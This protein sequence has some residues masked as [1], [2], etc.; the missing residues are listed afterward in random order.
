MGEQQA[1]AG[2]G[3][4]TRA[5]HAGQAPDPV[6]RRGRHADLAVDDVRP[7]RRRRPPGLRVLALGQPD[8]ARAGGVR[9]LARAG[10]PRPGVRQRARRRGQ[11]PAPRA[12]RA[13]GSLLGNDAYG[14]TFRLIAKVWGPHGMTVDGGRPHRPR[15]PRRQLAGGHGDG[16]AGDADQPAA[17]VHRHRGRRRRRPRQRRPRRRRQHVRHAVPAA[18]DHARRR[19]RRALGDEV[20]RRAQR[21]RR[22]V[23]RRRRRRPRRAAAVHAERRRRGARRRSTATSCCAA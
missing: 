15:R 14:G 16:V 17:D 18:A 1:P 11:R 10:P 9:R 8:A 13:G 12:V 21:R 3:F 5:V 20:P 7:G 4:E 23:R 22:R 2:Q 19:R 6:D